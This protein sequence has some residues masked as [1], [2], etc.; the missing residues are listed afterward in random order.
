MT[1][2]TVLQTRQNNLLRNVHVSDD[3]D[4]PDDP[5]DLTCCFNLNTDY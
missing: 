1:V 3:P 2:M 4:D 5:D